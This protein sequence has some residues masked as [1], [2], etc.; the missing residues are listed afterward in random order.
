MV[1]VSSLVG[2]NFAS[3]QARGLSAKSIVKAVL[4]DHALTGSR[5][6]AK[7]GRLFNDKG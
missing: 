5:P 3:T 6:T 7:R 4:W 1:D 2:S